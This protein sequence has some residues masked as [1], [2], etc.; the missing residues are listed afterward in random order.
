MC[1]LLA[2]RSNYQWVFDNSTLIDVLWQTSTYLLQ[3]IWTF[4][5]RSLFFFFFT[6]M[7]PLIIIVDST[8]PPLSCVPTHRSISIALIPILRVE[9]PTDDLNKPCYQWPQTHK[10]RNHKH[11]KK[12]TRFTWFGHPTSGY[13]QRA[14]LIW[15]PL[16]ERNNLTSPSLSHLIDSHL[17][18]KSP[19]I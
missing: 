11:N 6:L 13:I 16:W 4:L 19:L 12:N 10:M 18:Q 1:T 14:W 8:S 5:F 2:I 9:N 3:Q 7:P 17:L 15:S